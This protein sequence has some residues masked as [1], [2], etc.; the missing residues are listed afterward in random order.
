MKIKW[1]DGY[2][3]RAALID[4]N[5]AAWVR[6]YNTIVAR[7]YPNGG[8]DKCWDGYSKTTLKH[9]SLALGRT[10]SKAE[11][12]AL[13]LAD[14]Y[15]RGAADCVSNWFD[16]SVGRCELIDYGYGSQWYG[17]FVKA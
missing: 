5:G 16:A 2:S 12:N 13:P 10:I 14:I 17:G 15:T 7:V 8:I 4:D 9:I 6:S 1:L 11:W 3:K